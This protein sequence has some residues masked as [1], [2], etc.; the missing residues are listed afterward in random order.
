M[1]PSP[2]PVVPRDQRLAEILA[3]Y[4][5]EVASG[6]TPDPEALIAQEPDLEKEL[7]ALFAPVTLSLAPTETSGKAAASGSGSATPPMPDPQAVTLSRSGDWIL[8]Y[9][10]QKDF[11]N[12]ELLEQ[13]G[14]GGMGVVFRA[15]EKTLHRVVALKMIL[16]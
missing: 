4:R 14:Q 16:A 3:K 13:I 9:H 5:A 1:D 15:R 8:A 6:H 11:G 7:R 2:T 12:Y 10:A